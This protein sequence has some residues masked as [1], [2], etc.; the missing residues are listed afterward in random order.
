MGIGQRLTRWFRRGPAPKPE[1]VP[2][3]NVLPPIK[4][5]SEDPDCRRAIHAGFAAEAW[6][7][8]HCFDETKA[9]CRE[10]CSGGSMMGAACKKVNKRKDGGPHH[11]GALE[12]EAIKRWGLD[13][14]NW[15]RENRCP[16]CHHELFPVWDKDGSTRFLCDWCNSGFRVGPQSAASGELYI[17][18]S[19]IGDWVA[20]ETLP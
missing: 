12:S 18:V 13:W 6:K 19:T 17:R 4:R 2:I 16:E 15:V 1:G 5:C 3:L 7:A 20:A 14:R 9:L 11:A 10:C 8:E